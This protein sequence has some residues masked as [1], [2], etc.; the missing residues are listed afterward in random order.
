M[1]YK[2]LAVSALL[3]TQLSFAA[4]P[5]LVGEPFEKAV[6]QGLE[7]A[8]KTPCAA[9][10]DSWDHRDTEIDSRIHTT[11]C[12]TATVTANYS[13]DENN[14]VV[15]LVFKNLTVQSSDLAS[16]AP[17]LQAATESYLSSIGFSITTGRGL[18]P[19]NSYVYGTHGP[20]TETAKLTNNGYFLKATFSVTDSRTI[21]DN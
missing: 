6:L 8:N 17:I 13:L 12:G 14:S 9:T 10:Q 3:S 21:T 1:L 11:V 20:I 4:S 5:Q 2:F 19:R 7:A 16:N 18:F 15:A